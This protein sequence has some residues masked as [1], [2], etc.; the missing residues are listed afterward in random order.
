MDFVNR[1]FLGIK[2][3]V[4]FS[5]WRSTWGTNVGIAASLSDSSTMLLK[6]LSSCWVL[7]WR[8]LLYFAQTS[9]RKTHIPCCHLFSFFVTFVQHSLSCD[10]LCCLWNWIWPSNQVKHRYTFSLY[11]YIEV[12]SF[13]SSQQLQVC[14]WIFSRVYFYCSCRW[15][16]WYRIHHG[17]RTPYFYWLE[18]SL[19]LNLLLNKLYL[20]RESE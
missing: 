2:S 19:Y 4:W 6:V 13:F 17:K 7:T 8:S 15:I 20:S 14:D 5:S 3:I 12:V 18:P 16:F 11:G 10:A 1:S 9:F